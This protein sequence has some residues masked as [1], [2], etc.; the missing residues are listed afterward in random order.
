MR[1]I[2]NKVWYN[3]KFGL[4]LVQPVNLIK[5]Q[6]L[7]LQPPFVGHGRRRSNAVVVVGK[8]A[9]AFSFFSF[10]PVRERARPAKKLVVVGETKNQ[11]R[12]ASAFVERRRES[13]TS[14]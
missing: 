14:W 3:G 11:R 7:S 13:S 2:I 1:T 5:L 10:F 9:I 8:A 6:M 12:V 4:N